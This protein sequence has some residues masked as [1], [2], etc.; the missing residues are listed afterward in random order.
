MN[1]LQKLEDALIKIYAD[2]CCQVS[3]VSG[4]GN[5]T[6]TLLALILALTVLV[7]TLVLTILTLDLTLVL[8]LLDLACLSFILRWY[9]I[10]RNLS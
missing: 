3:V 5:L 2:C 8:D 1:N 9:I 7:P 4:L 10:V 6:M